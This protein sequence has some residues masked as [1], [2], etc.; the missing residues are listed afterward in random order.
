MVVEYG[1]SSLGPINFG[2]NMDVTEWGKTYYEQNS[3]SQE[4]MSKI[5]AEVKK[6]YYCC[7]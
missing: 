5:D 3:L 2:P 7:P 4:V 6:N 1:M